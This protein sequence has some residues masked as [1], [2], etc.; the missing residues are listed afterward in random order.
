MTVPILTEIHMLKEGK[1]FVKDVLTAYYLPA[2][3][4]DNPPVPEDSDITIVQR[5][6]LRV[7]TRS[8]FGTTTEE[9]ISSQISAL[10][11]LLGGAAPLRRDLYMV[12]V[13]EN[14]GVTCRRN[15]IWFIR[16][17]P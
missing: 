1:G 5:D 13:Y 11:E 3:F 7:I 12:A 6:P 15:E 17:E 4:Q 2:E 14:P 8:F 16:Q 10:W 9:T